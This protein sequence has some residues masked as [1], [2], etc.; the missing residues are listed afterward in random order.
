MSP[1]VERSEAEAPF[2]LALD[3]GS[4]ALRAMFFDSL[5]RS[6]KDLSARREY[7]LKTTPDG[8]A[9]LDP[10]ELF[11]LLVDALD[12][13]LAEAGGLSGKLVAVGMDTIV[14]NVLG[15]DGEG[16]PL[17]PIY[18]YADVRN[19]G[20]VEKLKESLDEGKFYER[21]GVPFHTSY[22]PARFLWAE[23]A[24]GEEFRR[25]KL[26]LSF[27]A[28]V[29]L[30]L[31]GRTGESLS[32]ASWSGLLNR[33]E[34]S[35]DEELLS[36][37]PV[38][39]EELPELVDANHP[40]VGLGRGWAGRWPALRDLPWFPAIGDGAAANV[41]SGCTDPRR[42]A[43][44]LGTTGAIRAVHTGEVPLPRG[45]WDYRVDGRRGLLGGALTEGGG[46]YVW[47][48]NFLRVPD[49]PEEALSRMSPDSHGLTVLPFL[50]GERS[51]GWRGEARMAVVGL[52]LHHGPL[53]LLRAGMEA[54][55]YRF[56]LIYELLREVLPEAQEV[57]ASGGALMSSPTWAQ[58]VADV[59]GRT[60][61]LSA[62][63]EATA[64][65]TAL[66]ALESTGTIRDVSE[67]PE[68]LGRAY[69]PDPERHEV[70]LEAMERQRRLY[71]LLY[72]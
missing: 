6:V 60:V 69:E 58:M 22:L 35:W 67:A 34:L 21:T 61:V 47:L 65:G 7:R 29:L 9:V 41:G 62:V 5:G 30:R 40:F 10:E 48:R 17:T 46:L 11:R 51:P 25:V 50:S 18:T 54:V 63:P 49:D 26:W 66:L 38:G 3:V 55:A 44:T 12:E 14:S 24:L 72:R 36:H 33:H 45:L 1:E 59:L 53:D 52:S 71:E 2:V 43:L 16:R 20:E 31:F 4:S 57:V 42:V 68:F 27:G 19:E 32:V 56:G 39:P 28:F 70:Y 13:V 8:G 23:G 64:R 15:V 37:L